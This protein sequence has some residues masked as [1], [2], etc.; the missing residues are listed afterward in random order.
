MNRRT[1]VVMI[2]VALAIV[3]SISGCITIVQPPAQ[4]T[5]APTTTL[6][7]STTPILPTTPVIPVTPIPP[8][9]PIITPFQITGIIANV[10]TPNYNGPC[11]M[12]L[13]FNAVVT[14]NT[15]GTINYRWERSDGAFSQTQALSFSAAGSKTVGDTW[16]LSASYSGWVRL[17]VLTPVEAVSNQ[18]YFL[19]NCGGGGGGGGFYITGITITVDPATYTGPCPKTINYAAI[20]SVSGPGVVTYKWERSDGAIA[21]TESVTFAAAGTRTVTTSWTRGGGTGWERLHVLTPDEA[22]SSQLAFTLT[23]VP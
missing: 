10:D 13:N 16:Q 21:P 3:L 1:T 18:V 2:M 8:I 14:A 22:T 9:T 11:P 23:C 20:I 12:V 19:V 4:T 6:P 17:R 5:P 7:P 15:A